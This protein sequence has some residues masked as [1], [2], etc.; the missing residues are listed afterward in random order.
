MA[1]YDTFLLVCKYAGASL[2]VYCLA[3]VGY[4]LFFHPLRKYPG[5]FWAK[6]TDA[7]AGW[8]SMRLRLPQV[9]QSDHQKYGSVMR[10]A[11]NRLVFNSAKAL[12]DIYDNERFTKS[13]VYLVT[14]ATTGKICVF[15]ALDREVHRTRRKLIGSAV[16]DAAMRQFEPTVLEQIDIFLKLVLKASQTSEYIEMSDRIRLLGSD[17]VGFLA[18]GFP[19]NSQT[20]PKY[21]WLPSAITFGNGI[22][23]VKMQLPILSNSVLSFVTNLLTHSELRKFYKMLDLMISTRL[24]QKKDA[25]RDLYARVV[26]QVDE[27]TNVR[28]SDV[29]AEAMFFFP[30]GGDSTATGISS[31]FFYLS[32]YPETYHKLATEIRSTF[33]SS[34]EIVGGPKLFGCRYLRAVIDEALR[35]SPPVSGTLWRQMYAD[36]KRSEPLVVDGHVIPPGTHVG[37]NLYTLHHNEEYFPD[38]YTFRPERWLD[39]DEETRSRMNYSFAAFSIGA[40][41]CAG[42]PMAYLEAS[43]VI[44]KTLWYFDFETVS[45]KEGK[46]GEGV[47][48]AAFGR[49][50]PH[51]FQLHDIFSSTQEG[52]NLKFRP[53]KDYWKDRTQ[54]KRKSVAMGHHNLRFTNDR[55][56]LSG[57]WSPPTSR[58]NFCEEDYIVT[59]YLAEFI[60]SLTNIAYVFLALRYMYGPGNRGVFRPKLDFMSI[61]LFVLGIGSFLFHATLRQT[62][63]FADELSMLGLTWSMLQSILTARQGPQAARLISIGLAVVFLAFSA[64]YINSAQIIY[65]VIAFG[66]G[67]GL[68]TLR[69]QYLY[70]WAQPRFPKAKSRDW[71]MRTWKSIAIC[72][73]GYLLWNIDLEYCAELR[74][75]RECVGL[76]WAWT[77]EL[78]GWWHILTA[79]GASMFMDVAREV[80]DEI[81]REKKEH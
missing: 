55:Y 2:F 81:S 79:V 10:H 52:P 23:N 80:R 64:F 66:S 56:S 27:T 37:V 71:N 3:T 31:V 78:H 49:H 5:P 30:A 28:M 51:E 33:N 63:E 68:V 36:D 7:Y 62:M 50:R 40:R 41:G 42:K 57:A 18:F 53:R 69:S 1:I 25:H 44:A 12:H 75:L 65:Q 70:H 13:E 9:T 14:L 47:P 39:A 19:L 67:I 59:F 15:N 76:P 6:I 24:S 11:P 35:I 4:N 32:R 38:S 72:L 16:T 61:S 48:G 26:D 58:A 8:H 45:G 46:L 17:I 43:L 21:R 54:D 20:D 60:N 77:L 22:S 73:F 74:A 29:W 34:K